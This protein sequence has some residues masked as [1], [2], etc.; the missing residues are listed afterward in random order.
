MISKETKK[1]VTSSKH[2]HVKIF[3]NVYLPGEKVRMPVN[4]QVIEL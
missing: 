1:N 4:S 3:E 2:L